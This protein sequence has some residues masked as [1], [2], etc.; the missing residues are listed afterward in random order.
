MSYLAADLWFVGIVDAITSFDVYDITL[1]FLWGG[2]VIASYM[3]IQHTLL[4]HLYSNVEMYG[5][6]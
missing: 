2:D 1:G 5:V 3:A 4:A 6:L